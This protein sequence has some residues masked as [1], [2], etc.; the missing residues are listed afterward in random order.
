M[1]GGIFLLQKCVQFNLRPRFRQVADMLPMCRGGPWSV[2]STQGP[3]SRK[4]GIAKLNY[5]SVLHHP[6][7]LFPSFE[8][9]SFDLATFASLPSLAQAG[10]VT[11]MSSPD[12]LRE[13][14][15]S[16]QY[17]VDLDV[18]ARHNK[19]QTRSSTGKSRGYNRFGVEHG[20][21]D[22]EVPMGY[23]LAGVTTGYRRGG[24]HWQCLLTLFTIHNQT[25]NSWTMIFGASFIL[26]KVG[27]E[28]CRGH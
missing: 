9:T 12:R 6:V 23:R 21:R 25:L 18:D 16:V 4:Q 22:D 28:G 13:R 10:A 27:V 8:S 19:S 1:I 20:L 11:N 5:L 7:H 2:V 14:C 24:T 26:H 15:R 17:R 3:G